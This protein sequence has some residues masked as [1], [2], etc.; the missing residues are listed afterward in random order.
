MRYKL[1]FTAALALAAVSGSLGA[2]DFPSAEISNGIVK[3]KIYLPDANRGFYRS[4]RFDWSGMIASL[5]YKGHNFYGPWFYRIDPDVY[6]LA[7]DEKGVISAPFTA[8]L[9]PA[10]AFGGDGGALGFAEARPGGTFIKIGV[11]VLRKPMNGEP[12]VPV[13]PAAFSG[14]GGGPDR[15]DHSRA[16]TLVDSGKWQV[17]TRKDSVEFTQ[18]LTDAPDGYDYVYRK[19]VRLLPGK[20]EMVI[21]HS[22]KNAGQKAIK[23]TVYNH[24]F[25]VMDG[26]GPSQDFSMAVPFPIV[27]P[28]P[29]SA[30]L[31]EAKGN[32]LTYLRAPVGEERATAAIQGFG[33][34]ARD[35]DIRVENKKLGAGFR[36]TGDRPLSSLA[37]WSIRTVNA[38]EPYNAMDIAPGQEFTW[39]LRYEYYTLPVAK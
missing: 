18:H 33:D 3:A 37:V 19:V 10:E 23:A 12:P 21:E 22:L 24:N 28:R 2:A 29:P 4:T 13:R 11:G 20:P 6:D 27:S 39:T 38:V 15:Y 35:Y 8:A 9:G 17:K 34:A 14:R 16:Y 7:Y 25:L 36:V 1:S 30:G 5:E 31:L 26:Q 32:Q